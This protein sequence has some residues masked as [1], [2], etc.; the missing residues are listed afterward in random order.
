M[1]GAAEVFARRLL[2]RGIVRE[3]PGLPDPEPWNRR[4]LRVLKED[5][6]AA[7][8]YKLE[9]EEREAREAEAQLSP[10][11]LLVHAVDGQPASN[12]LPLNGAGLL[13]AALGGASGTVNGQPR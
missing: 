1:T 2:H 7:E 8:Q 4:V 5:Q 12:P 9:Q 10:A 13:R 11:Q 6:E 3:V